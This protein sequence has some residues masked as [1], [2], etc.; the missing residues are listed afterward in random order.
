MVFFATV[1]PLLVGTALWALGYFALPGLQYDESSYAALF[2]SISIVLVGGGHLWLQRI[3]RA[4]A[5]PGPG[6]SRPS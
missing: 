3:L 6:S 1:H 4:G 5:S 2:V